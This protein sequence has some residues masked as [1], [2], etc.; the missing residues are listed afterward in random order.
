MAPTNSSTREPSA[1]IVISSS[2]HCPCAT[3]TF[4]DAK[5]PCAACDT[6]NPSSSGLRARKVSCSFITEDPSPG[7]RHSPE[8]HYRSEMQKVTRSRLLESTSSSLVSPDSDSA[9]ECEAQVV[10]LRK[11]PVR[12]VSREK[13]MKEKLQR[14]DEIH[15]RAHKEME[16]KDHSENYSSKRRERRASEEN[17][18]AWR[19]GR[20]DGRVAR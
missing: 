11:A 9:K 3:G 15:R 20:D 4:D 17:A 16:N 2:Y 1:H 10:A 19:K 8:D 6:H 13:S 12:V 7:K 18:R 5:I 14:K